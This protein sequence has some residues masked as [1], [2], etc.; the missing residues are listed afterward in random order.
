MRIDNTFFL[1]KCYQF[2]NACYI[3]K[4]LHHISRRVAK[5]IYTWLP[6]MYFFTITSRVKKFKKIQ[7][8]VVLHSQ[9][10]VIELKN[11]FFI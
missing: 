11:R 8:A 10:E 9:S 4:R 5:T 6:S 3:N 7:F 2:V 1:K